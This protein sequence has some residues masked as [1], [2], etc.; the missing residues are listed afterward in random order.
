M[1]HFDQTERQYKLSTQIFYRLSVSVSIV[2]IILAIAGF[3]RI[4]PSLIRVPDNY[5][6][7]A[8]YV[9]ARALNANYPLYDDTYMANAAI[10]S[11]GIVRFPKYIYPPFFAIVLRPIGLLSFYQAK[12]L[13]FFLNI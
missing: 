6:F 12:T 4:L 1:M 10:T 5:D 7:A 13:W 8:Y 9:A 3:V 2:A 11:E